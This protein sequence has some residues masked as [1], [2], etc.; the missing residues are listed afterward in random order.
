M[1]AKKSKYTFCLSYADPI[2]DS[3]QYWLYN[4]Q[5]KKMTIYI[6]IYMFWKDQIRPAFMQSEGFVFH[7]YKHSRLQKYQ[8]TFS[9]QSVGM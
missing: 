1:K 4:A 8:H 6:Y 2:C 9:D 7:Q 3:K 5:I